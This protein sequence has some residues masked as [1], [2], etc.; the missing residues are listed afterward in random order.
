MRRAWWVGACVFCVVLYWPGLTAWFQRD[1]FGWLGLGS[2]GS[3]LGAL[4]APMSQGTV[5]FLGDRAYF[6]GL[7]W[8]FGLNPLAFRVC[9]FLTMFASLAVLMAI[10]QRMTRSALAAGLAALLWLANSALAPAMTWS[11]PYNQILCGLLLLVSLWQLERYLE[12]GQSRYYAGQ[13][14][15]FLAGFGANEITVVYP[16]VAAAYCLCRV[17]RIPRSVLALVFGSVVF[18]VL[19]FTL[20]HPAPRTGLYAL[21]FDGSV[22][23]T[24]LKHWQNATGPGR[25]FALGLIGRRTG[26][27]LSVAIAA[28]VVLHIWRAT[29]AKDLSAVF[30]LAWFV[31]ALAPVLPLRDHVVDYYPAIPAIGLAV[32]CAGAVQRARCDASWLPRVATAAWVGIY[33]VCSLVAARELTT[34]Y[35]E[36]SVM[37]RSFI[38]ELQR[39]RHSRP[40]TAVVVQ[41]FAPPL[42]GA[43]VTDEA[44]RVFGMAEVRILPAAE[45]ARVHRQEG[46]AVYAFD[47]RAL[48][49]VKVE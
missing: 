23:R 28:G 27:W 6:L 29:R 31:L 30:W 38:R 8:V 37:A 48:A 39:V 2:G 17:R 19:E 43:V 15:T 24:F 13:W 14:L 36:D 41:S 3:L 49:E 35:H 47:G 22:L 9:A 18:L 46:A 11:S 7:S 44:L 16:A 1:D 5:R 34:G 10:V 32:L 42:H 12:T 45:C 33:A 25:L 26:M 40:G 20:I 4:F 21:Y